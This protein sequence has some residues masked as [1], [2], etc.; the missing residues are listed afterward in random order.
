MGADKEKYAE[1]PTSS[2]PISISR[3]FP[4][5]SRIGIKTVLE[6]VAKEKSKGADPGFFTDPGILRSIEGGGFIND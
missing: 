6:S 1:A 5:P 4:I 2:M 3:G